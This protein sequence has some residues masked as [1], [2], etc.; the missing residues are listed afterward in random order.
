MSTH[1]V[2]FRGEIRKILCVAMVL[3]FQ[4]QLLLILLHLPMTPMF[5]E[6]IFLDYIFYRDTFTIHG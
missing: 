3:C 4:G 2:C 5:N 6:V 1:T